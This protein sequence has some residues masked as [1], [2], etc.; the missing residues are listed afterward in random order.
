M[1]FAVNADH[2][3]SLGV[4]QILDTLLAAQVE[5]DPDP[6]IAGVNQAEGMTAKSVHMPVAARN[7]PVTHGNGDLMQ[8]LG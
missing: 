2:T 4:T 7:A 5:L 1:A 8:S 3:S 6:L